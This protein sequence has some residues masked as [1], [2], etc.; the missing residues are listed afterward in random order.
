MK[1]LLIMLTLVPALTYGGNPK[2]LGCF[3]EAKDSKQA[4]EESCSQSYGTPIITDTGPVLD[5]TGML[6]CLTSCDS[7][8]ISDL[9][10]CYKKFPDPTPVPKGPKKPRRP[11]RK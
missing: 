10:G 1:K 3:D 2:L 5:E 6:E 11:R 8:W 9:S 4:C 7:F